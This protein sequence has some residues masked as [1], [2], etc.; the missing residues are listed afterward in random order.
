MT[1]YH[2][3]CA[4]I[5]SRAPADGLSAAGPGLQT[6]DCGLWTVDRRRVDRLPR[7]SGAQS[8]GLRFRVISRL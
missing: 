1:K 4:I 8:G 2:E 7:R 5:T 6:V 3:L